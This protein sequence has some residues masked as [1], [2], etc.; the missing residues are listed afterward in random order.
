MATKKQKRLAMQAKREKFLAEEKARNLA[1]QQ[2][3]REEREERERRIQDNARV[4]NQNL[5][6]ILAL[7]VMLEK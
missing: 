3:D 6:R 7:A 1:A 4:A 5:S 2:R